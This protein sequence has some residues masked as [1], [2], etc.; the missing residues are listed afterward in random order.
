VAFFGRRRPGV[1]AAAL[2]AKPLAIERMDV[3][4][5]KLRAFT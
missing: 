2:F 4:A 1:K 5:V 3:L